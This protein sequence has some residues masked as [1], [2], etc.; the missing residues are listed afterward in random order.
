MLSCF[1]GGGCLGAASEGAATP[2]RPTTKTPPVFLMFTTF[3]GN[4][5]LVKNIKA[6][7]LLE[8]SLES[9]V[10]YIRVP[11]EITLVRTGGQA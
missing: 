10:K 8:I 6:P 3:C 11:N 5:F 1:G 4:F 2:D 9:W 7:L